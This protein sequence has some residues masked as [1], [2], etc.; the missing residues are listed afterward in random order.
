MASAQHKFPIGAGKLKNFTKAEFNALTYYS[1][2]MYHVKV[3]DSDYRVFVHNCENYYTHT[4]LNF[5]QQQ[6]YKI[7][8]VEDD[9]PNA[10]LFAPKAL[11]TG[12]ELFGPFVKFLFKLKK[13]GHKEI[14][15]YLNALWGALTQTNVMSISNG[16][17]HDNKEILTITPT[18]DGGLIFGTA[19]KDNY[20]ETNFARIKPFLLSYGRTMIA[21]IILKNLDTVVRCHTDGI[22]CSKRITNIEFGNNLGNLKEEGKGDCTIT[23]SNTYKFKNID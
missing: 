2:G 12:R 22:I 21:K 1:F 8:L 5:A 20:Y 4:D 15:S 6:G 11:M 23:N 14:K 7:K 17:V 19:V 13:Q 9:E 3:L 10:L 16:V 18:N